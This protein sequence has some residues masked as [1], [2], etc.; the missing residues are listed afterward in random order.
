VGSALQGLHFFLQLELS[1]LEFLKAEV[2]SRGASHF[3]LDRLVQV[4][5]ARSKLTD[6]GFNGHRY[7]SFKVFR[8]DT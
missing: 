2:V 1:S 5:M 8:H 6:A 7:A 4:L 3:V